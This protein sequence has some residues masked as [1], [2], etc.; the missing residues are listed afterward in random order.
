MGQHHET[1]SRDVGTRDSSYS[2]VQILWNGTHI[3]HLN[4]ANLADFESKAVAAYKRVK[5]EKVGSDK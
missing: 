5:E 2:I 4:D 1:I 3:E